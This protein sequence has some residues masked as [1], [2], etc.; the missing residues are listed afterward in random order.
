[1]GEVLGI[2]ITHAPHFQ[3]PDENMADILRMR[4]KNKK[5]PAAMRD[6]RN[7]L[8]LAAA[9]AVGTV[10]GAGLVVL[11]IRA[12]QSRRRALGRSPGQLAERVVRD[13]LRDVRKVAGRR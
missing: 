7:W 2:G 12:H 8:R 9:V 4:L 6:P 5:V 11:R 13:A 10:A 3:Y 1:M